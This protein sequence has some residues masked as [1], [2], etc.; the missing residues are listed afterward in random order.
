LYLSLSLGV[1]SSFFYWYSLKGL[2]NQGTRPNNTQLWQSARSNWEITLMTQ[3][4]QWFAPIMVG[5]WLLAEDVAYFSVA[6]RI[7]MLTS[8][9]LMAV[10]L[11][12]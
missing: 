7:V 11:V 6:Q 8:F 2:D 1:L 10:N 5:I 3:T 9:I 12:V 4:L